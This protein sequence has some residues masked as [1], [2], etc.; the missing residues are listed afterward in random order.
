V[1]GSPAAKA[2]LEEGDIVVKLG[3]REVL[4]PAELQEAVAA[5]KADDQVQV[6]FFRGKTKKMAKVR[7]GERPEDLEAPAVMTPALPERPRERRPE[8]AAGSNFLGSRVEP[9]SEAV[10]S[11]L[12]L[13]KGQ[14]LVIARVGED[15]V[16]GA[17][18]LKPHDVLLKV[19]GDAVG[20]DTDLQ[21]LALKFKKGASV[22]VT[23]LRGGKRLDLE[24]EVR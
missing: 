20:E 21:K 8:R 24:L 4:K 17:M 18:D 22:S 5:R 3:D 7:L 14:G 6:T 1:E 19:D 12:G 15:S 16:L 9:A 11:H 13:E 23:V 10:A 2:G